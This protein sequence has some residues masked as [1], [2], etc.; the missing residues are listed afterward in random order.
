MISTKKKII[1]AKVI[2]QNTISS[3]LSNA[4]ALTSSK[5]REYTVIEDMNMTIT[6]FSINF[7]HLI[8]H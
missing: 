7:S 3:S 4:A 5:N 2:P 8:F 1:Q 6:V